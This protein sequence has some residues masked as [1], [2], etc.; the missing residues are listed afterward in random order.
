MQKKNNNNVASFPILAFKFMVIFIILN[1]IYN[2]VVCA[3]LFMIQ[4]RHGIPIKDT[5]YHFITFQ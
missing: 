5:T 3:F 2:Q 1:N 4:S